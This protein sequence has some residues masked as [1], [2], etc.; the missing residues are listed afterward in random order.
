M[1]R[2]MAYHSKAMIEYTTDTPA[3]T[4]PNIV[5]KTSR[6][7]DLNPTV[8]LNS[9]LT[10]IFKVDG[11]IIYLF[12]L[13]FCETQEEVVET[14]QR[15]FY[16]FINNQTAEVGDDVIEWSGGTEIPVYREYVVLVPSGNSGKQDFDMSP[17]LHLDF[18]MSPPPSF[19]SAILNG[20]EIFKLN[21]S[22]GLSCWPKLG[23]GSSF[24]TPNTQNKTNG[25]GKEVVA[26]DSHYHR[27][28][29][30][31]RY[32]TLYSWF[33]DFPAE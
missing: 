28:C 4:T 26:I 29:N 11:G 1:I 15:V 25:E 31:W 21:R 16:I 24:H 9:N 17:P 12:K 33:S 20:V 18:D 10:G 2:Q 3:Y 23:P 30:F 22:D 27:W 13:H 19:A 6:T 5:Y 8:N 32:S 14:N 7:M